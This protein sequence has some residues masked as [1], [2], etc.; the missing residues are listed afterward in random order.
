MPLYEFTCSACGDRFEELVR[1]Q[2]EAVSCPHCSSSDVTR[3]M[4]AFAIHG[5][6]ADGSSVAASN[7]C[8]KTSCAGCSSC[9]GH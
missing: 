8:T 4:S 9:G 6:R 7:G 3:N 5:R 1:N 2:S